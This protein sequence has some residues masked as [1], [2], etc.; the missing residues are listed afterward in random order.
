LHG[1][2]DLIWSVAFSR[3]GTRIASG[4]A[5]RTVRIWDAVSG[6]PIGKPLRGHTQWVSSVAFSPDGARIVSG[7][8]DNTVRIWDATSGS[9]VGE[10]LQGHSDWVRSVAFSS[11][12]IS[13]VSGSFDKTAR[14]WDAM[15]GVSIGNALRSHSATVAAS[16][17]TT[18]MIPPQNASATRSPPICRGPDDGIPQTQQASV[19]TS[20]TGNP[21][22]PTGCSIPSFSDGS[23][24]HDDG[25]VTTT[26]GL[27]LFWV[28]PEHHLGLFWPRSRAIIGAHP[29]QLHMGCFVHGPQWTLCQT[30]DC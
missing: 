5:D 26:D 4:S 11:D 16:P 7:S 6:A 28:P 8:R 12:G 17:D 24:L 9:P 3:D 21:I 10:P 29:V 19:L 13:I 30:G 25:W 23:I 1:H 18:R 20:H 14:I 27:L 15:L 2:S 22:M